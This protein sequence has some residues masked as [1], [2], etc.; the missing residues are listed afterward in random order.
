MCLIFFLNKNTFLF[1]FKFFNSLQILNNFCSSKK[2]K[3]KNIIETLNENIDDVI[4]LNNNI[5]SKKNKNYFFKIKKPVFFK[6][7]SIRSSFDLNFYY[8]RLK[9][10]NNNIF[11]KKKLKFIVYLNFLKIQVKNDFDKKDK[12]F[13]IQIKKKHKNYFFFLIINGKVLLTSSIGVALKF[14]GLKKKFLK[15]KVKSFSVLLSVIKKLYIYFFKQNF[16]KN[17]IIDFLDKRIYIFNK[18]LKSLIKQNELFFI[19]INTNFGKKN[20]KKIKSIK[21]H[22]RK[23]IFILFLEDLK[24]FSYKIV[25]KKR[26]FTSTI[27]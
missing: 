24:K 16:F 2:I 20:F 18:I 15:R 8:D 27:K 21:R 22:S 17:F 23:K 5:R 13:I 12:N 25:K 1:K 11:L 3:K 19:N 14:T 9:I 26:L 10:F 4:F 6:K 7:K